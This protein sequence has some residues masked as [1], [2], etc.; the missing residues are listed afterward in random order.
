MENKFDFNNVKLGIKNGEIKCGA[1]FTNEDGRTI[2]VWHGE[3]RNGTIVKIF[4][5][6]Y[7]VETRVDDN[8][9]GFWHYDTFDEAKHNMEEWMG[10]V[11]EKYNMEFLPVTDNDKFITVVPNTAFVATTNPDNEEFHTAHCFISAVRGEHIREYIIDEQN[12]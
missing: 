12:Y 7:V 3:F 4:F 9:G 10:F 2:K 6:R 1:T 8:C 11:S 5:L